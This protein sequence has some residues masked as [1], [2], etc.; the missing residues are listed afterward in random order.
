MRKIYSV[1]SFSALLGIAAS[2]GDIIESDV[3]LT[4]PTERMLSEQF[5]PGQLLIKYKTSTQGSRL[6]QDV[7]NLIQATVVEEIRTGAMEMANARK[8]PKLEIYC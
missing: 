4:S 3:A 5:V 2:C 1:L 8:A 6:S 7:L